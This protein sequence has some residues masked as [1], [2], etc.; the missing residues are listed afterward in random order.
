MSRLAGRRLAGVTPVS[1]RAN[2]GSRDSERRG[3]LPDEPAVSTARRRY[4]RA[5]GPGV[6]TGAADDDPA[7]ITTYSVAGAQFG[8][9]LLWLA[10]LTWPLMAAVQLP[11]YGAPMG[12][13]R[14]ADWT[15]GGKFGKTDRSKAVPSAL[16]MQTP[17]RAPGARLSTRRQRTE[18]ASSRL[19]VSVSGSMRRSLPAP[20]RP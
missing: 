16:A 11:K 10:P 7:G 3:P 15:E 5:L 20:G 13:S 17:V 18:I 9:G 19:R 1:M 14:I 4:L 2:C 12:M 8:L 6:I